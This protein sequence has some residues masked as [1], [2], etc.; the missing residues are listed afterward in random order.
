MCC[1]RRCAISKGQFRLN[2][3][4]GAM[5]HLNFVDDVN[6]KVIQVKLFWNVTWSLTIHGL[7][8][9]RILKAILCLTGNK[10]V[11]KEEKCGKILNW[12]HTCLNF[13]ICD[14]G[15]KNPLPNHSHLSVHLSMYS[16]IHLSSKMASSKYNCWSLHA[17]IK[18]FSQV[19]T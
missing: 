6:V 1:I 14:F 13:I 16:C 12:L 15:I 18:L 19:P 8:D 3:L 5:H 7:V 10:S 9:K 2:R 11:F 17:C 4:E